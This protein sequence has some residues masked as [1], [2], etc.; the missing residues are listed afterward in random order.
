MQYPN[1]MILTTGSSPLARGLHGRT[2]RLGDPARIIPARAGF[3]TSGGVWAGRGWDH[4]RSRGVYPHVTAY[5]LRTGGSSPLARGLRPPVEPVQVGQGII[6]ARAG[7]TRPDSSSGPR[8]WDHPRSRGVYWR[9][10]VRAN[11]IAGSSPLAR[12]LPP[13][14][15][16]AAP[17]GWDNPRSRGVYHQGSSPLAR[18]L[19]RA[20]R[21]AP[22]QPGII[23]ARAGFTRLQDQQDRR[24][25]DHPR[26]RG[27][28]RGAFIRQ[29]DSVGSSPLARGLRCGPDSRCPRRRIIPA[30]AGFTLKAN[31]RS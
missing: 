22:A 28:Y 11:F 12:G 21:P 3:T 18:G 26:S 15:P 25:R 31:K 19:R 1:P 5:G 30:R 14:A 10:L 24:A 7:F 9:R 6:P 29:A 8:C 17:C 13:T 2:D 27:V 16:S 20:L 23:P 4:P